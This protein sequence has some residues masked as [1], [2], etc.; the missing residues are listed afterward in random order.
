MALIA[1]NFEASREGITHIR[2]G[3]GVA[4]QIVGLAVLEIE[5]LGQTGSMSGPAFISFLEVAKEWEGLMRAQIDRLNE[6]A[7]GSEK[8]VNNQEAAEQ[9]RSEIKA[10]LRPVET[11]RAAEGGY[12]QTPAKES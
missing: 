3:A 8:V 2:E 12:L 6:F 7:D 4:G 5:A 1:Q 11:P 10:T 9:S